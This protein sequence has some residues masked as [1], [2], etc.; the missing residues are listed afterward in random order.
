[1]CA[2]EVTTRE[3]IERFADALS[4]TLSGRPPVAVEA[5]AR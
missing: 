4:V 3:D 1:V 2:T 5:G